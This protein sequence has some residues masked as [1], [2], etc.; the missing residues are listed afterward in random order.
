MLKV[1]QKVRPFIVW[2]VYMAIAMYDVEL[3]SAGGVALWVAV[4]IYVVMAVLTMAQSMLQVMYDICTQ[5]S[6]KNKADKQYFWEAF[7]GAVI[8]GVVWFFW[9]FVTAAMWVISLGS[10]EGRRNSPSSTA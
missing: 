5:A 1:A 4:G 2:V 8:L 6:A 10:E 3:F 9:P 7:R